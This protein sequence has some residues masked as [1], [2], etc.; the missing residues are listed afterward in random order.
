MINQPEDIRN[1]KVLVSAL[2]WGMGHTTRL[3][4]IVKKLHHQQNIIYFAGTPEQVSIITRECDAIIPLAL[5]GYEIKLSGTRSTYLQLFLQSRKFLTAVKMEKKWVCAACKKYSIDLVISDNRYGFYSDDLPSVLISHQLNLQVPVLRGA[6]NNILH[7]ALKKFTNIW[8]PDF[9]DH[10]LSG[11]LSELTEIFPLKFIGPLCRFE[12]LDLPK[13]YHFVG[14]VSGPSPE[15]NRFAQ[16]LADFLV[17]QKKPC[18]LVGSGLKLEG[19]DCFDHLNTQDLGNLIQ[20][21]HCVIS[22]AGYTTIMELFTLQVNAILIPTPGQYEQEYLA[23]MI[24]SNI[25]FK[26]EKWLLEN[27]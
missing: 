18:A 24:Y 3:I 17:R 25:D 19:I 13:K 15:R 1:Q 7:K 6:A 10:K 26:T 9:E 14:I 2:D 20:S 8:I 27:E 4:S 12:K 16:L 22:R 5:K 23:K 21:A 11:K